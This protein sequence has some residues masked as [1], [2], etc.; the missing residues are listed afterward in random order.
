M[1]EFSRKAC[2]QSGRSWTHADRRRPSR[3]ESDLSLWRS[4][5]QNTGAT[6]SSVSRLWLVG[7]ERSCLGS[8]H[9]AAGTQPVRA[10][11][12]VVDTSVPNEAASFTGR[13]GHFGACTAA[14][15]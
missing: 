4:R 10:N 1:V 15:R 5:P 11:V 13:S 2:V 14:E 8:T 7:S 12:V 6:L 9:L 3:Y